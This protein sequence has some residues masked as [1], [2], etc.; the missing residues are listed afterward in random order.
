MPT[1][2]TADDLVSR[3]HRDKSKDTQV[4]VLSKDA[5][6]CVSVYVCMCVC[7]CVLGPPAYTI[8]LP[9]QTDTGPGATLTLPDSLWP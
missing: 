4:S 7:V 3:L 6:V 9:W 5:C 8:S 2:F 1:D